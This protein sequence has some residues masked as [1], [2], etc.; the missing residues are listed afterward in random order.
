MS[1][2][3]LPR[4][5]NRQAL[6]LG[7]IQAPIMCLDSVS[8]RKPSLRVLLYTPLHGNETR[9]ATPHP[10]LPAM[11]ALSCPWYPK[12][13]P[14]IVDRYCLKFQ[15]LHL[16][17]IYRHLHDPTSHLHQR[18]SGAQALR[19][20]PMLPPRSKQHRLN[21][22]RCL[23]PRLSQC[24]RRHLLTPCA[25]V[26]FSPFKP[27]TIATMTTVPLVRTIPSPLD[28]C[29]RM[30]SQAGQ[31]RAFDPTTLILRLL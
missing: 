25:T 15:Y 10:P 13:L 7:G 28:Q 22:V 17:I 3:D 30:E 9:L 6:P 16:L 21:H 18:P 24:H 19:G 4:T 5:T 1:N 20:V 31:E 29:P 12:G 26:V 23:Q 14:P 8:H 2:L 11:L 27:T